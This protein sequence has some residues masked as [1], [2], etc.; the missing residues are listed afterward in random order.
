MRTSPDPEPDGPDPAPSAA[1]FTLL[2][3]IVALVLA[4][5]LLTTL[6]RAASTGVLATGRAGSAVGLA[7]SAR[8][9]L[10]RLGADIPVDEGHRQG[11][12]ADG[13]SWSLRSDLLDAVPGVA[14]LY[15]VTVTV[16]RDGMTASFETRRAIRRAPADPGRLR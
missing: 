3:V 5:L 1:G 9:L 16:E 7:S 6:F 12:L 2:E 15:A 14:A 10:D 4:G 8:S 13:T 11:R